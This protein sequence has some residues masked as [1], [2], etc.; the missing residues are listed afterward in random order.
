MSNLPQ[1]LYI[2]DVPVE[3]T[4]AGSALLYRLL[5]DYPVDR[6]CIV[7]GNIAKSKPQNR[8]PDV[9]YQ[10]LS[11]GYQR[12]LS[13]RFISF[14]TSYL[15]LTAKW[16]SR[17]LTDLVKTFKPE[18]ILTV[19]HGFSWITAAELAKRQSLPLHLIIHDEWMSFIPVKEILKNRVKKVFGD[20]YKQASSRFCVS[21]YMKEYYYDHYGVEGH[22][23]YPSRAKNIPEFKM[24][25]ENLSE[26]TKSFV[27][28]YA[29][30]IVSKSY[31][32]SLVKLAKILK[33][34]NHSLIIYSQLSEDVIERVGLNL[35][36]VTARNLIPSG[37]LIY[38]LRKE[39]HIL[40][41]PMSFDNEERTN[42]EMSFPSKLTDYTIIGLPLLIRG[43]SYC[44]AV[45]WA[46][47]NPGV[48]EVIETEDDYSLSSSIDE[49]TKSP[50]YCYKLAS[51][52][53]M[54]GY[55]YFSHPKVTKGFYECIVP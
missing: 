23:L 45:R 38:K 55:E 3:S 44:S 49:L 9:D 41:V 18:A 4:V 1:L 31:I 35:S 36:N 51:N 53:L 22:V 13:S 52:T 7:E 15:F 34:K 32:N 12:L 2:G 28:A 42:A 46:K 40:F 17:Q 37:Q 20:I 30:S 10:T 47:E 54:I 8:L 48:A 26:H 33:E 24:P 21:P 25:S 6:L 27:F 19:A 39:A 14:Y 16:R 43:P 11:V 29:G 50:E 5:Q